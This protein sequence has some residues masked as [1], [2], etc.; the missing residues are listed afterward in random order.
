[1]I[2]Y[3]EVFVTEADIITAVPGTLSRNPVSIAINKMFESLNPRVTVEWAK[4]FLFDGWRFHSEDITKIDLFLH[5][6]DRE[7]E[8]EPFRFQLVKYI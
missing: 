2:K 1:M 4:H 7:N 5:E 3:A 8:V 6:H